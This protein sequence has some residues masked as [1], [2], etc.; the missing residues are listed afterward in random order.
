MITATEPPVVEK[1]EAPITE[2]HKEMMRG[3]EAWIEQKK[4]NI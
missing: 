4:I 1:E 2:E 3:A